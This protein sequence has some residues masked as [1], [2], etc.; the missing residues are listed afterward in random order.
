MR[1]AANEDENS[2]IATNGSGTIRTK[3]HPS[4]PSSTG[5][6][7]AES[8][9]PGS[10]EVAEANRLLGIAQRIGL[11]PP[12][13]QDF[14]LMWE[15]HTQVPSGGRPSDASTPEVAAFTVMHAAPRPSRSDPRTGLT[16]RW[17]MSTQDLA[18]RRVDYL[19][20]ERSLPGTVD[21]LEMRF[22]KPSLERQER[23]GYSPDI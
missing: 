15:D 2:T 22:L 16:S 1:K 18:V 12:F 13:S 10:P 23:E 21:D 20:A 4:H 14:L 3:N 17:S 6:S 5:I 9:T 7:T 19:T 8:A 11:P